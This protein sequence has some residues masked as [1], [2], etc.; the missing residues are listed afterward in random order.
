MLTEDEAKTKWCPF[1]RVG[2]GQGMDGASY[3]RVEHHGGDI[4][5]TVAQCIGSACMAWRWNDEP[6]QI[7]RTSEMLQDGPPE[8]PD[9]EGWKPHGNSWVDNRR[10]YQDWWRLM[11]N[12]QGLCGMAG[13]A[14]LTLNTESMVSE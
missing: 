9:G 8:K 2:G 4:S 5:H 6:V 3:N 7:K 14:Q 1:A 13:A 12:R 10:Q 11:P